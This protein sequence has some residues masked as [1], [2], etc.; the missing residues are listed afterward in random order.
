MA[1]VA[2][3]PITAAETSKI[4]MSPPCRPM[5]SNYVCACVCDEI[6][7]GGRRRID[8]G[9]LHCSNTFASA[10]IHSS[11]LELGFLD[12]HAAISDAVSLMRCQ[13]EP[14]SKRLAEANSGTSRGSV[15]H[16]RDSWPDDW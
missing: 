9:P 5:P 3:R 12:G 13:A 7:D 8:R 4:R 15:R 6:Q 14:A 1:A 2:P 11:Q 16:N 10:S